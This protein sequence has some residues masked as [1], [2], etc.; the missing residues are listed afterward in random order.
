MKS[1]TI[2]Y[3]LLSAQ[4][5][6]DLGEIFDYTEQEFGQAQASSYL[7]ELDAIFNQLVLNP[8]SG[9]ERREIRTNLRSIIH[10]AHIIFYRVR[11]D[12]IRIVRVLHAS[13][14]LSRF[15]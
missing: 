10:S 4:A 5:E 12:H 8:K 6:T 2:T 9:R 13:R 14:D 15:L 3:Y 7:M 1:R 11:T